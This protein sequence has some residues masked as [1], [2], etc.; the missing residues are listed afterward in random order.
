MPTARAMAGGLEGRFA[1]D[2]RLRPSAPPPSPNEMRSAPYVVGELLADSNAWSC[3]A[4]V[5]GKTHSRVGVLQQ[6]EC[7]SGAFGCHPEQHGTSGRPPAQGA[8]AGAAAPKKV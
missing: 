1:A 6:R 5:Q 3:S 4:T 7:T 2:C 8:Q